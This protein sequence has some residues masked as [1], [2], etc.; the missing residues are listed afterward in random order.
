MT[1]RSGRLDRLEQKLD[2]LHVP[3]GLAGH[4]PARRGIGRILLYRLCRITH[5]PA[6]SSVKAPT[7]GGELARP[8]P[9]PITGSLG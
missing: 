3:A 7:F 2:S 9:G 4:V 5:R 8:P 6:R 1:S